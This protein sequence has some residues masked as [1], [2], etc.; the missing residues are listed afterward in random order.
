MQD[1]G[2]VGDREVRSSFVSG[3]AKVGQ[4]SGGAADELD[5]KA[6][7]A[8]S[9]ERVENNIIQGREALNQIAPNLPLKGDN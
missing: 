1:C 5:G 6:R 3:G 9:G 4:W 7:R 2:R 8:G